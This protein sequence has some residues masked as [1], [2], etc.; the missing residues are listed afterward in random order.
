MEAAKHG[1]I[2]VAKAI[3][4]SYSKLLQNNSY[5]YFALVLGAPVNLFTLLVHRARK[6]GDA[7]TSVLKETRE[8]LVASGLQE[9]LESEFTDQLHSKARFFGQQASEA[10]LA[11][12][13]KKLAAER[14]E[15]IV[16]ERAD[17]RLQE[18]GLSRSTFISTFQA[19]LQHPLFLP[20]SFIPGLPLYLLIFCTA[21]LISNTYLKD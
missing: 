3:G 6:T 8:E 15:L 21:V 11:G 19:L 10:E 20:L 13:A 2:N 7:H 12:E 16:A 4:D 17:D 1:G 5:R 18:K 9:K 14:F